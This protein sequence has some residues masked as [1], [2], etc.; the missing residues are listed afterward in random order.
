VLMLNR[1]HLYAVAA[2]VALAQPTN[3]LFHSIS[4]VSRRRAESDTCNKQEQGACDSILH[5]VFYT[6]HKWLYST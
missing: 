5:N 6:G 4:K 2:R 1:M 3:E